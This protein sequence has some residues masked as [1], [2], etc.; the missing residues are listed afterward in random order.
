MRRWLIRALA[1]LVRPIVVEAYDNRPRVELCE[2][3]IKVWR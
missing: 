1:R 2:N 3:G